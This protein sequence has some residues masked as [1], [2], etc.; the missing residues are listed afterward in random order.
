MNHIS[1]R[2]SIGLIILAVVLAFAGC[3]DKPT[4]P[5]GGPNVIL[6]ISYD[7]APSPKL[8]QQVQSVQLTIAGL[9]MDTMVVNT[10]VTDSGT[11]YLQVD[12]VPSGPGRV[13]ILE[14]LYSPVGAKSPGQIQPPDIALYRGITV[15]NVAPDAQVSVP[16]KLIPTVPMLK[17]T[18]MSREV[19]SGSTF[20]MNLVAYNMPTAVYGDAIFAFDPYYDGY[21]HAQ[22]APR[23][24]NIPSVLPYSAV[25]TSQSE[26]AEYEVTIGD[27]ENYIPFTGSGPTVLATIPFNS[28]A[29]TDTVHTL[30]LYFVDEQFSFLDS[31]VINMFPDIPVPYLEQSQVTLLPLADRVVTF[32]DPEL[33]SVIRG[34]VYPNGG[35][36]PIMLSQVLPIQSLNLVE[37]S[38][39]DLTGI[40]QL[41]NLNDLEMSYSSVSNLGPVSAL[42][43]MAYLTGAS[44][45][46]RDLSPIA[47]LTGIWY[48]DFSGDSLTSIAA[49]ANMKNLQ[50]A[51][52]QNNRISDLRPLANLK[53]VYTLRLSNNNLTSIAPLAGMTNLGRVEL[54]GN[55]ISDLSAM[56]ALPNLYLVN[57][58]NNNISDISA[59]IA[60]PGLGTG[61]QVILTGNTDIPRT[62]VDLLAQKG[63]SITG[64]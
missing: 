56:I 41:M 43:N 5:S 53:S 57:L 4:G 3:T 39:K 49:L 26:G 60:N 16:I 31:T 30:P 14:L 27:L 59:L 48:L 23:P 63:V 50:T 52:L 11:F 13:F 29:F 2:F 40:D 1:R 55:G 19:M 25:V 21:L 37:R 35:S 10:N 38:I 17:L 51:N 44:T 42:K 46:I 32:P 24:S 47:G 58:A 6:D 64:P 20:Y 15:A 12:S 54:D 45:D 28:A 34:I 8:L 36:Q 18:P 9:G 61:D 22:P 7:D 33:E 62:Q